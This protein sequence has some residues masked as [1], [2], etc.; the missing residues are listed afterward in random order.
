METWT[1]NWLL[2][3][4][5]RWPPAAP[6][7]ISKAACAHS[8]PSVSR[9]KRRTSYMMQDKLNRCVSDFLTWE[10]V[11]NESGRHV[12]S[13]FHTTNLQYVDA[14]IFLL[15]P[16]YCLPFFSD[17]PFC[18]LVISWQIESDGSVDSYKTSQWYLVHTQM[19]AKI[20]HLVLKNLSKLMI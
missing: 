15:C 6:I 10:K 8:L 1:P 18:C 2:K 14:F 7:I 9:G 17:S 19:F 16:L 13:G 12:E 3:L 20:S 5:Q 4:K 11:I